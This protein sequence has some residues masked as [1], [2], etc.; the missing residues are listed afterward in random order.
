MS[1]VL[2]NDGSNN[3]DGDNRP[4]FVKNDGFFNFELAVK[5]K[6]KDGKVVLKWVRLTEVGL[7]LKES[8]P[9]QKKVIDFCLEDEGNAQK[10]FDAGRIR[11]AFRSAKPREEEIELD[12][13]DDASDE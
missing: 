7:G 9:A 4:K 12:M 10:L 1:A 5:V 11:V 13:G 3:R 8:I 2:H 6:G